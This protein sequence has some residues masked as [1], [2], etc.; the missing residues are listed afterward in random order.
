MAHFVKLDENNVAVTGIVVNNAA[1]DPNNEEQ[2]GIEF[3]NNLFGTN[4]NW[5]Q[6]S[7]NSRIRGNY[8][9]GL[10]YCDEHDLFMP[11]RCHTEAVLNTVTAKWECTNEACNIN[12]DDQYVT[13]AL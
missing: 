12:L 13:L 6:T 9:V 7:Y 10:I 4:D 1:L 11:A 3:I 8:G 5:K 2:S